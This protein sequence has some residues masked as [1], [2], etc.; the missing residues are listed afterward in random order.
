MFGGFK[1]TRPL[2]SRVFGCVK[3][4]LI[5]LK[6]HFSPQSL[7][8]ASTASESAAARSGAVFVSKPPSTSLFWNTHVLCV[9]ITAGTRT[10][11]HRSALLKSYLS[12]HLSA[13]LL[14]SCFLH[15]QLSQV[16]CRVLLVLAEIVATLN[17]VCNFQ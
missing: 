9:R 14:C 2:F 5:L 17:T 1:S 7:P 8:K 6:T 3:K 15:S 11:V 16:L 4:L 12:S 13:A 10:R